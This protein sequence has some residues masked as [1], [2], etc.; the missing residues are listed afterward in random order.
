L[1]WRIW[2]EKGTPLNELRYEWTYEDLLKANAI[3][4]MYGAMDIARNY[5][6]EQEVKAKTK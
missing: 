6:D 4:D 2:H 3:L 5:L 1:I